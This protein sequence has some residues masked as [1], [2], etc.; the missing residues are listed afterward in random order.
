MK[1]HVLPLSEHSPSHSLDRPSLDGPAQQG[2]PGR[3]TPSGSL[4]SQTPSYNQV[5]IHCF[6]YLT[7]ALRS[8][9]IS[10]TC[11]TLGLYI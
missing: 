11:F 10:Y 2:S 9:Y 6:F 5:I 7:R 3:V 4:R 1:S 8:V